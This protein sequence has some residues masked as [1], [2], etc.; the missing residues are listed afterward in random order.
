MLLMIGRVVS[1]RMLLL[2]SAAILF[3]LA[4]AGWYVFRSATHEQGLVDTERL[5]SSN[6]TSPETLLMAGEAAMKQNRLDDALALFN[7]IPNDA[8]N[9]ATLAAA[10]SGDIL[11]HQGRLSDAEAKF[12]TVLE[13]APRHIASHNRLGLL[14]GIEGRRW[15]SAPHLFELVK[16]DQFTPQIL[17][18]L[19]NLEQIVELPEEIKNYRENAPDD[20]VPLLGLARI[21]LLDG[22]V[23]AAEQHLRQVI[24]VRPALTAAQ[25]QLGHLLLDRSEEHFAAWQAALPAGADDDPEIWVVRGLWAGR[26]SQPQVAARSF[27]EAVRRH[28]NHQTANYQLAQTLRGQQQDTE[29]AFFLK[30][31]ETLQSLAVNLQLIYDDPG[32][33]DL[34]VQVSQQ[35]ESLGRPWEAWA[36]YRTALQGLEN[37]S[38][39]AAPLARLS[40]LQQKLRAEQPPRTMFDVPPDIQTLLSS[41]PLPAGIGA[42]RPAGAET[43]SH[44][45][46]IFELVDLAATAGLDFAYYNSSDPA[47]PGMRMFEFS[48]GGV[49]VLDFDADGWPDLHFTQGRPWTPEETVAFQGELPTD[50]LFRN[51]GNGRFHDVTTAAGVADGDYSQGV[52]VGDFDGD[53]FPD[54]YI[55][56]IGGNRFYRNNGDGT[57]ADVSAETDT[58]GGSEWTTSCLL[59]DLNADG[60]PDLYTVN[61]VSGALTQICQRDGVARACTPA[62][63]DAQQDH[64]YLN[65]GNGRFND[66]TDNAGIEAPNGKGLGIVAADFQGTGRLSLFVANDEVPNFFF[67]NVSAPKGPL[68]FQELALA[69]GLAVDQDGSAQAC[70]GVAAGDVDGDGRLDLFVTN[71]FNESNTFYHQEPGGLFVD[72]TRPAGLREPSYRMLGFG[73]QFVDADLDG[74]RDLILV[75][76]DVDDFSHV[77]GRMYQ[78]PPQLYHNLGG[79]KFVEVPADRAGAW[80]GGKYLGRS[81]ARL[82]WDRDGREDV[83]VSNLDSPAALVTNRTADVAHFLAVRLRGTV[84]S[85]DAIGATVTVTAAGQTWMQQLTAGDGYQA[86]NQRQLIFGLGTREQVERL[87]V[88]WPG[89]SVQTF[90]TVPTD[91]ELLLIEG[92]ATI[93]PLPH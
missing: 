21:E 70:M 68:A 28:P 51:G 50:R 16:A 14:L 49:G 4:G 47:T 69:A 24:A 87:S 78:M 17:M 15:E 80:F 65:Q 90:G 30:R 74:S 83:A 19:G 27:W 62:A 3:L 39:A 11:L 76:G 12:R 44:S 45:G 48:G 26:H 56:N 5:L 22:D 18:F 85:R 29:A 58:I 38:A 32:R 81:L 61:Y 1:Q 77:P 42:G 20:V 33:T 25:A 60:L 92:A 64:V 13:R 40:E 91:R 84:D 23:A 72:A 46:D 53:G 75:N 35:M 10:V 71:Y 54:L 82:D 59:A 37:R 88:R 7:R 79:G 34:M 63:F 36:W 89:G 31:A 73:T 9:A 93:L 67:E 52:T 2:G 6:A 66:V 43:E 86:S 41:Y 57:Y 55:A 8:G